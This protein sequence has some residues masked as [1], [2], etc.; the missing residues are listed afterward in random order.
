MAPSTRWVVSEP[1]EG[2]LLAPSSLAARPLRALV[3]LGLNRGAVRRA[4][5][6]TVGRMMAEDSHPVLSAA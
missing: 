1:P 3:F 6:P 2:T 5:S 4:L